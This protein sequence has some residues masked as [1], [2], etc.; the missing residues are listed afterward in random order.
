MCSWKVAD[1]RHMPQSL[2]FKARYLGYT[3]QVNIRENHRNIFQEILFIDIVT[4]IPSNKI[5]FE[6]RTRQ[7]TERPYQKEIITFAYHRHY[8]WLYS[9]EIQ[10]VWHEKLRGCPKI[11]ALDFFI[12]SLKPCWPAAARPDSDVVMRWE[13]L[14][15]PFSVSPA[16][17]T[18]HP[19]LLERGVCKY[20]ATLHHCLSSVLI[21]A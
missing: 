4:D 9:K 7:M 6:V 17:E 10:I 20:F 16:T 18:W 11:G 2:L 12:A 5:H 15:K 14:N 3:L 21:S 13:N 19:G 8:F 1:C